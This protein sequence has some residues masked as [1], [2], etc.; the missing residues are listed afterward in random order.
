MELSINLICM[1]SLSG[2][3][4]VFFLSSLI[5]AWRRVCVCVSV[6]LSTIVLIRIIYIF[7]IFLGKNQKFLKYLVL[8]GIFFF[9]VDV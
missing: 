8:E 6:C 9:N 1:N 3:R 2:K 4:T 5:I 7:H